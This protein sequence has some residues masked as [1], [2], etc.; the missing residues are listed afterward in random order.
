[1]QIISKDEDP[2]SIFVGTPLP[3]CE[4]IRPKL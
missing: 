3:D 1:M 2:K 4:K